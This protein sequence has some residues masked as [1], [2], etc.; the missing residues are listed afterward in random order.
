ME[1]FTQCR[2]L[3]HRCGGWGLVVVEGEKGVLPGPTPSSPAW[4]L[5]DIVSSPAQCPAPVS[6]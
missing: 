1:Y 6:T 2:T 4:Q 3:W 5:T